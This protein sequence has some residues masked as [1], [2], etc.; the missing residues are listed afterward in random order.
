MIYRKPDG[1]VTVCYTC[2]IDERTSRGHCVYYCLLQAYASRGSTTYT[3]CDA[4]RKDRVAF[5]NP[6]VLSA[7][8]VFA[9]VPCWTNTTRPGNARVSHLKYTVPVIN[10]NRR[11]RA[12]RTLTRDT[13]ITFVLGCYKIFDCNEMI[14]TITCTWFFITL[15]IYIDF[16]RFQ[17]I[18]YKFFLNS[19][20]VLIL[21]YEIKHLSVTSYTYI[22]FKIISHT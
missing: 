21:V 2:A 19:S 22:Y 9:A 5:K 10:F 16:V 11:R 15:D 12:R 3:P 18:L 4:N 13:I 6:D 14:I 20:M 1:H 7:R 8:G 17:G